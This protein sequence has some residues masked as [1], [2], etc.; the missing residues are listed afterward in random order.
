MFEWP[1]KSVHAHCAVRQWLIKPQ[2]W[3]D[4]ITLE[5]VYGINSES[6]S[7]I[8]GLVLTSQSCVWHT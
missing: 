3:V 7:E 8:P 4:Y 6:S 1:Y 2:C 5:L